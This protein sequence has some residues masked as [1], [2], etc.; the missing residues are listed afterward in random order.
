MQKGTG[1]NIFVAA[2]Y[3][4][5]L[6]LGLILGQN[7]V[8]QQSNKPGSSLVPIGLSDNS[9]K[10]QQVLDLLSNS[11]VDSLNV[12][13]LQNGAINH[14]VAHLDP[15][16]SYLLPNESK[17]QSEALEG[18][19][20]GIGLEFFNLNDTLLVVGVISGG[21]AE[22]AGLKVG[23]RILRIDSTYV[24]GRKVAQSTVDKMVRGKKGSSVAMYV[25]RDSDVRSE[26]FK[27]IRDQVNVSSIDVSYMVKPTIGYVRIRR[28]G[29]K[30]AED[31]K[32]TIK[33][34]KKQGAQNLILDLRDNGG[35]YF[36]IA[37]RL[38]SE[39]FKDRKMLVY[40]EGAHENKRE[41]YSEGGGEYTDGKLIVLINEGTASASEI[42]A[43]AVQDW[44]RATVVGRR[45]YGKGIVQEQFDFLD[46]S[47]INL[48]I[49]RYYTPLGRSIQKKYTANWSNMIDY[50]SM[51]RGLWVLDTT[52]ANAQM[53]KTLA[54]RELFSGG[55]ISPDIKIS[56]DSNTLSLLY[57][58]IVKSSY[59]EQFVYERFTKQLPA[60]SIENFIQGYHLPQAEYDRFILYLRERDIIVNERRSKDLLKL[61]QSDIEA[62]VGRYYFGREAYF[63]VKNR[64]DEYVRRAID[65]LQ[66]R[67]IDPIGVSE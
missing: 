25:L 7:Y 43:G 9:Y 57:Q 16:S 6:F 64:R 55:G 51:Y 41:Y 36:H 27:I 40:T 29:L 3:A 50:A 39:F 33:E 11:Y 19:F 30:T 42:V 2:T 12:D 46:G 1:R 52:F 66:P 60:Y 63:K 53:Y 59:L 4:A 48:S 49:S 23:D 20:E 38:A 24:S 47:R 22:K 34:L 62:I 54:G 31:F 67:A 8:D 45:S 5:T 14:I 32:A 13:S 18:T 17:A 58:E 10:I 44:D 28:F 26:P 15:Y 21:P 61:I 37:I 35:G 56:I 65:L